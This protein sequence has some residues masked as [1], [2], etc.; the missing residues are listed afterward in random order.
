MKNKTFLK[1]NR[2]L[3]GIVSIYDPSE[4]VFQSTQTPDLPQINSKKASPFKQVSTFQLLQK[5]PSKRK[6]PNSD[7]SPQN[8]ITSQ[9]KADQQS[10]QIVLAQIQQQQQ[11]EEEQG[12][13]LT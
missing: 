2:N 1:S 6:F 10:T 5:I 3:R 12:Q 4:V 8:L 11:P 13:F 9:K 7:V